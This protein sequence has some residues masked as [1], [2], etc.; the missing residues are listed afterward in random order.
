MPD[1]ARG[2][3]KLF[4]PIVVGNLTLAHRV[5]FAPCGRGRANGESVP[6]PLMPTYLAQRSS[7]PGTLLISESTFISPE[8]GGIDTI[9]G[10]WSAKQVAAWYKATEAVHAKGAYI[11]L[12][13]G[14]T[15]R[16]A[17]PAVMKRDGLPYVSA[18][19]IPLTGRDGTP[20]PLTIAEI[21]Q[22]A[23]T[24]AAAAAKAI[25]AGFDGVELSAANGHLLDQFLQDMSNKRTDE[26]GGSVENRVRFV[27]EVVNAITKVVGEKKTSIRVSPWSRFNDMGMDDPKPTF[28]YLVQRLHDEY[29]DLAY[30]HVIEPRVD[31]LVTREHGAPAGQ[32]NDFIREIWAPRPLISAGGYE[33]ASGLEAAERT[34]EL[35]AYGRY[36]VANPDLPYRLKHDI[37]LTKGD[38]SKYYV[39]GATDEDGYTDYPFAADN[40]SAVD[41]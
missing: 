9:P 16:S 29:P 15:G 39:R 30:I 13:L 22:Y 17:Q 23:W 35:I 8:A 25:A 26:Y 41:Y 36:F 27:L 20:R 11:F 31:G 28:A 40:K 1:T 18:S 37:P 5:V 33:R 32:S 3:V 12:Q 4:Q 19:D 34:G 10:I 38:R 2:V 21:K 7:T 24:F 6:N 14:A